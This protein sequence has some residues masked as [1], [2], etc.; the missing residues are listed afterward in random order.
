MGGVCVYGLGGTI[1][2]SPSNGETEL[3]I[4][5]VIADLPRELAAQVSQVASWLQVPSADL[6]LADLIALAAHIDE[7]VPADTGVVI[8]QGTDTLEDSAFALDLLIGARR[9]VV[10]TGAMRRPA[11]AGWDGASNVADAIRVAS[12]AESAGR[13]TLVVFDGEIHAAQFVRKVHAQR[14]GAFA[15]VTGPIG[16]IS[17]GRVDIVAQPRRGLEIALESLADVADLPRVAI[18]SAAIGED[19][20]LLATLLDGGYAG[21]V[22]EGLGGGHVPSALA[23]L[24]GELSAVVPVVLTRGTAGGTALS[25]TYRY[26]GS[27]VDLLSRGVI[28]GGWLSARQARVL[29]SLLLGGGVELTAAAEAFGH[30]GGF[31]DRPDTGAR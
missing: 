26:A 16:W 3:G 21:L 5:E 20:R 14:L 22:I 27:E 7:S 15:S 25:A 30:Y 1:A 6:R 11:T 4:A 31:C 13:G 8:T 10:L 2:V 19:G 9:T 29:L 28:G 17:E 24:I 18:Y 23:P 12:S